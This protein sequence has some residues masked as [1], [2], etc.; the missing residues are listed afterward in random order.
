M[1]SACQLSASCCSHVCFLSCPP[2]S[3]PS[4][5]YTKVKNGLRKEQRRY[6]CGQGSSLYYWTLKFLVPC[7][8]SISLGEMIL[9]V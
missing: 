7:D 6:F 4:L 9:K 5:F 8:W 1:P 3:C 2:A